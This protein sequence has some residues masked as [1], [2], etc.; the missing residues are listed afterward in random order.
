MY[1][2]FT[3]CF[4]LFSYFIS[5]YLKALEFRTGHYF[6]LF[7]S[8]SF[9]RATGFEQS[10]SALD[11]ITNPAKIEFPRS[12]VEVVVFWNVPMHAWLKSCKK[13]QF[14]FSIPRVF[15]SRQWWI[16][17]CRYVQTVNA[18]RTI[19]SRVR[20]VFHQFFTSRSEFSAIRSIIVVSNVHL[21]RIRISA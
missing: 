21:R 10:S 2:S 4:L 13:C 19:C 6:I 9:A 16:L 11:C 14:I 8:D 17:D 7:M 5:M 1:T 18:V 12:L 20:H 15:A 3:S